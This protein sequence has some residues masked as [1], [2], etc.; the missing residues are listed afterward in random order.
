[1]YARLVVRW[2]WTMNC[3]HLVVAKKFNS[4]EQVLVEKC[5]NGRESDCILKWPNILW[6]GYLSSMLVCE[7][8]CF[9]CIHL[10]FLISQ[11][12][13]FKILQL[14]TPKFYLF[15]CENFSF[16]LVILSRV[17]YIVFRLISLLDDYSSADWM[18]FWS[19]NVIHLFLL[20]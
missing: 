20:Q 19:R 5:R 16:I 15:G 4:T 17:F 13:Y 11:F 7:P 3:N 18:F 14:K 1:M 9:E 2:L 8:T 10:T 6:I 12:V